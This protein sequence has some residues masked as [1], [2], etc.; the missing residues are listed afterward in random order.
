MRA[1]R[2]DVEPVDIDSL[3]SKAGPLV[4]SPAVAIAF[5]ST[6]SAVSGR[7]L[8]NRA[9]CGAAGAARFVLAAM[10]AHTGSDAV[11]REGCDALAWL[12]SMNEVNTGSVLSG[13]GIDV[14]FGAMEAHLGSEDVQRVRASVRVCSLRNLYV[15]CVE[16]EFV[17][18]SICLSICLSVS[19]YGI[20][21]LYFAGGRARHILSGEHDTCCSRSPAGSG[22][23]RACQHGISQPP[24]VGIVLSCLFMITEACVLSFVRLGSFS[25][26]MTLC[27]L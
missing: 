3:V 5:C 24:K 8:A 13:G 22:R 11:S 18:L 10:R 27:V 4:L 15:V 12:S 7:C 23:C 19:L 6:I 14:I 25:S 2:G 26:S 20:V 17:C 1:I 21:C 9:A 16:C